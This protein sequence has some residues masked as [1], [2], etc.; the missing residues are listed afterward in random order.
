MKSFCINC[1]T[2]FYEEDSPLCARCL[3]AMGMEKE[4]KQEE[5]EFSFGE[6]LDMERG[7]KR[8]KR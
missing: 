6:Y 7:R 2:R 3:F 8:G 5:K 4:E 1:S